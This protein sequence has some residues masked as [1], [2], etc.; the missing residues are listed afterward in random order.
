LGAKGV[1]LV[2]A[3]TLAL[4][5]CGGTGSQ[6][7][8]VFEFFDL[9]SEGLS[10]TD[11]GSAVVADET[12]TAAPLLVVDAADIT[13]WGSPKEPNAVFLTADVSSDLA[14]LAGSDA[15]LVFRLSLDDRAF[16]GFIT[17]YPTAVMP[18]FPCLMFPGGLA[19]YFDR[20]DLW[21]GDLKVGGVDLADAARQ[22][23][24][25]RGPASD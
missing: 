10:L 5:G 18:G 17:Y 9:A 15:D 19:G 21:S 12:F 14:A 22:A 13:A 3:C 1:F 23:W 20:V 6:D 16:W 8:L 25:H 7:R 24:E 11:G 2:A 4:A